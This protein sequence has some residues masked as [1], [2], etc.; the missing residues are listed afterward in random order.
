[1]KQLLDSARSLSLFI[2]VFT[3]SDIA[4]LEGDGWEGLAMLTVV[5]PGEWSGLVSLSLDPKHRK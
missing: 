2:Q 5:S 4:R 1:M 3:H